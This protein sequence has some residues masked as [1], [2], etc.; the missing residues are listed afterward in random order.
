MATFGILVRRRA[1]AGINGVIGAATILAR[2]SR[3]A[4]ARAR[5][6]LPLADEGRRRPLLRAA[7]RAGVAHPPARRLDPPDLAREPDEEARGPRATWCATLEQLGVD[8]LITIGGDDTAYSARR[9]SEEAAGRIRVAHVPKT[10]DNDL[11]LPGGIPTFGFETARE[12]GHAHRLEPDGGRAHQ[13]ALV[14]RRDDGPHRRAPRARRGQGGRR[15]RR[16][17]PRGVP[18]RTDPARDRGAHPRRRDREA[19]LDGPR[20]R[21]RRDRRGRGRAARAVR[22]RGARLRAARR[23]RPRPPR[24]GAARRR[25]ARRGAQWSQGARHLDDPRRE[26]RRLRAAL[27]RA[28]RLR[29]RLHP[30]SRGRCRAHAARRHAPA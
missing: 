23:A 27:R 17:D 28:Q 5:G 13:P 16:V 15:H 30:R 1:G 6:R 29:P 25:A 4:R 21:R 14:L 10:I 22:P 18:A 12:H 3:R 11:P 2:R 7:H 9:V 19:G 20:P 24:R 26:G 8:H